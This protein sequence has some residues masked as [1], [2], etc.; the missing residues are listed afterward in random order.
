M[1]LLTPKKI[2][3][4]GIGNGFV[5]NYLKQRGLNITTLDIDSRLRLDVSGSILNIPFLDKKFE[6]VVCYELL[7]HLPYSNFKRAMSEI[8]RVSIKHAIISLPDVNRIYRLFVEISIIGEYKKFIPL[9]RLRKPIHHFDDEHYW[10]IGKE[11]YSLK[12]ITKDIKKIGFE[13][14]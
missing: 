11:D 1:S 8:F 5:S 9:I 2:L 4:I 12:R 14:V 10:E 7:E 3:E 13:I 6:V